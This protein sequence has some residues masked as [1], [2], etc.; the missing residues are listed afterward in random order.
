[1]GRYKA[2]R[3]AAAFEKAVE[4]Y[5]RSIQTREDTGLYDLDGHPIVITRF[6]IPPDLGEIAHAIGISPD[7]WCTYASGEYGEDYAR[8]C[9]DTKSICEL[10]L[11][12]QLNI[13]EKSVEGIKF[14]LTHN[15]GWKDKHEIEYGEGTRRSIETASLTMEEKLERLAGISELCSLFGADAIAQDGNEEDVEDEADES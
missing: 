14:N 11:R 8:V 4:K 1:M 9:A 15:Y 3:T 10:W 7:T 2:Y 5:L 12:Q 6:V 13:R